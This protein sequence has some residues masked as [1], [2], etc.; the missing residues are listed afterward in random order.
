MR[1]KYY[2]PRIVIE[3]MNT[4]LLE[5]VSNVQIG[6]SGTLDAKEF[7]SNYYDDLYDEDE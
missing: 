3:E 4:P 5:N 1:K 2:K 7:S 6:G